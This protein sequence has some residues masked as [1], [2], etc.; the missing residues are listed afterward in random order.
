[1]GEFEKIANI[2]RLAEKVPLPDGI[3]RLG[4]GDDCCLVA[5]ATDEEFALV[6]EAIVAQLKGRTLRRQTVLAYVV[7]VLR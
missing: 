4:I 3:V 5:S 2:R 7:A 1:M 6:R